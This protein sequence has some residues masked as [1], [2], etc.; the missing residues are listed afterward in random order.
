MGWGGVG[1]VW[2]GVIASMLSGN[3][4]ESE[5]SENNFSCILKSF[6]G[7]ILLMFH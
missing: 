5:F 3:F 1:W 2:D 4:F 6:D 7:H